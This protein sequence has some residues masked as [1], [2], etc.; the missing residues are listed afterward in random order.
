VPPCPE[1]YGA[2]SGKRVAA[3]CVMRD[4]SGRVLLLETTYKADWEVPGGAA[5]A[6]ESP[7]QTAWREVQEELGLDVRIGKLM[8]VDYVPATSAR[9]EALRFLFA[10]EGPPVP[11]RALVLQETEIKSARYC[12]LNEI[13]ERASGRLARRLTVCMTTGHLPVCLEDGAP[14]R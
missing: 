11:L 9:P 7:R 10:V 4:G 8:C 3:G 5:E 12:T 14:V 13:A 2:L 1:E 6:D